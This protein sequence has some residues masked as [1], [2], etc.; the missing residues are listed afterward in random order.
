ML[1]RAFRAAKRGAGAAPVP[2]DAIAET[3]LTRADRLVALEDAL[4]ELATLDARKAQVVE[5]KY[6]GG[7][8]A[9]EAAE[10]LDVSVATV[11]RDWSVARLW[12]RQLLGG[13]DA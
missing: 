12:L 2:L 9:E 10:A 13:D 8:T 7:L 11:E 5:L 4:A 1:G 6:F 3:A